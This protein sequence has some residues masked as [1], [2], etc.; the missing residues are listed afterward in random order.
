MLSLVCLGLSSSPPAGGGVSSGATCSAAFAIKPY[1]VAD[2]DTALNNTLV[3]S[4]EACC[5]LC[6]AHLP[7]GSC[8]A[9]TWH[10]PSADAATP[11]A[12]WL[13]PSP[14]AAHGGGVT[15]GVPPPPPTPAPT[16]YPPLPP[17]P[18]PAGAGAL[19][20]RPNIVFVLTDDQDYTQDSMSAMPRTRALFGLGSD[21]SGGGGGG[22][23]GGAAAGSAGSTF[24]FSRAYVTTPICCPSRSSY[25]TGQYIH[26]TGT[27][28]NGQNHG[29]AGAEFAEQKEPLSYA[30]FLHGRGGGNSSGGGGGGG[31]NYTTAF[32][33][34]YLNSYGSSP[35][36]PMTHVPV[37]WDH[38]V[39]L[40]GNSVYY[41]YELS[42]AGAVEPHHDDYATDYL[43]DVL[44]NRS[45]AWLAKQL[46]AGG[47]GKPALAVVHVP[48]PHRPAQPAPQYM[49][50]FAN[51]TAPRSPAWNVRGAGKHAP[52]GGQYP[53]MNATDVEYSDHLWRRRLR[54]LRSV[55]DLVGKLW[56]TVRDADALDRT[57]F[58][59]TSDHGYHSGQWGVA[60]CKM[61]PYEHDVRVPLFVRLPTGSSTGGAPATVVS[62]PV[63]N[64]DLAPT[65][66]ELAGY[67]PAEQAPHMDGVSWVPQLLAAPAASGGGDDGGDGG[68]GS[69]GGAAGGRSWLLEYFPIKS[70]GDDV[71]TSVKGEDGWCTDPDV[72][73]ADCPNVR[74]A[75]DGVNNTYACV[76]TRMPTEDTLYCNFYDG[77]NFEGT[78][79]RS[80]NA[81]NWAEWYDLAADPFQLRNVASALP[82]AQ[83][84]VLDGRLARLIKCAGA[85]DCGAAV[86]PVP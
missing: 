50:L 6:A 62:A 21:G 16:P 81:S 73:R 67:A 85:A 86:A 66:L 12:C 61:M 53:L 38:W 83:R 14:A 63:L 71:Q 78:S 25:L 58:V 59:Y 79:W 15:S 74:V 33:G 60:Y 43:T 64:I 65:L 17:L 52:F 18:A 8:T 13:M 44:A 57:V 35:A 84:A 41:N 55:D 27:L 80:P 19:G 9:W 1:G 70:T 26:N 29:C 46:G 51:R 45:S 2:S 23:G 75:V 72:A 54:A 30:A 47:G 42:V 32:F 5:S 76:R 39:A 34:K 48:A 24:N 77:T 37:G 11:R 3:D 4:S 40:R 56:D 7:A 82:A 20:F 68:G 28:Q 31:A 69:S 10:P 36:M 49:N 22:G